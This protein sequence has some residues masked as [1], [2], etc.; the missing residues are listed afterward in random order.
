M[1]EPLTKQRLDPQ[2]DVNKPIS[3]STANVPSAATQ[4]KR[5]ESPPAQRIHPVPSLRPREEPKSKVAEIAVNI[6][7]NASAAYDK[8]AARASDV[9]ISSREKTADLLRRAGHRARYVVDEYPLHVIGVVG[10]AAFVAGVLLRV[11]R[12]SHE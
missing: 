6:Q 7:Q 10:G 2:V 12:S 5:H 8:L 1:A 11:W 9:V 3:Q 4:G